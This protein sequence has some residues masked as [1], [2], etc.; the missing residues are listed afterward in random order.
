MAGLGARRN[1][2]PDVAVVSPTLQT[3]NSMV[4]GVKMTLQS[5]QD[6]SSNSRVNPQKAQLTTSLK[7]G[8]GNADLNCH[9]SDHANPETINQH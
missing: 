4:V 3:S 5:K 7:S 6:A 2:V 8:G 9:I 1:S